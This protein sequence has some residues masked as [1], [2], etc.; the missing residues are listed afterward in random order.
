MLITNKTWKHL[1]TM[2]FPSKQRFY[3]GQFEVLLLKPTVFSSW[4]IC[5]NLRRSPNNPAVSRRW[6]KSCSQ[7]MASLQ[8]DHEKKVG[9]SSHGSDVRIHQKQNR[10]EVDLYFWGPGTHR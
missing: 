1:V 10:G 4:Q 2:M 7:Y 8:R 9:E 3:D 5:W 6:S